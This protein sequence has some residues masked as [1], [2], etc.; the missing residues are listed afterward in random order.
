MQ[1]CGSGPSLLP[2][3]FAAGSLSSGPAKKFQ[4]LFAK[5]G[6]GRYINDRL[7]GNASKTC[8]RNCW[9]RPK[10]EKELLRPGKE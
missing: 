1:K 10:L 2:A 5:D 6:A 8:G 7:I 4:F 3:D 9:M